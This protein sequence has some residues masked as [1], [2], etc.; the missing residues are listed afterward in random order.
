MGGGEEERAAIFQ[1][2]N[3]VILIKEG[4]VMTG[5]EVGL[6]NEVRSNNLILTETKM[7]S[8]NGTRLLGVVNKITL[9]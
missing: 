6:I 2:T 7:G 5:N 1:V 8:G 9:S 3:H 4:W